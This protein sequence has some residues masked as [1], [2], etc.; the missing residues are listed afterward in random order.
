VLLSCYDG[1]LSD[2]QN[3]YVYLDPKS[4]K[5]GFI[6]WD[7][8]L[9]W[10]SFF[11]LGTTVERERASIWHPWVG[12]NRFLERVMAAPEFREMYRQRLEDFSKRLFVPERLGG[13]IDQLA[14]LLRSSIAAESDYRLAQF[15]QCMGNKPIDETKSPRAG[16]GM[17]HDLK[18]F[19]RN[20][21]VSVRRQLDGQSRGVILERGP[22]S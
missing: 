5:F 14:S 9:A 8:D 2:G 13:R 10:G 15:E 17:P 11:L 16:A 1:I 22:R 19:I 18:R 12:Q 7:L 20:R 6:P 21:R 3:F 4:N